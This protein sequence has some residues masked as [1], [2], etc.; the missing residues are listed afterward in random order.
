MSVRF[1]R[2][3][4]VSWEMLVSVEML[5]SWEMLTGFIGGVG[6][7]HGRSWLVSWE[8]LV[9]FMGDVGCETLVSREL[10]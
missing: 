3:W 1:M 2:C 4:F 10:C 6:W 5:I 8:M 7:F 9:G